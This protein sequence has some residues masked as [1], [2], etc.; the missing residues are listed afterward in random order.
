MEK[1]DGSIKVAACH[2]WLGYYNSI[3]EIGRD[4]TT[5]VE[6]V[7][8]V[9][10]LAKTSFSLQEDSAKNGFEG[11]TWNPNPKIAVIEVVL[12]KLLRMN[13]VD[14]EHIQPLSVWI[15]AQRTYKSGCC[16]FFFFLVR[17]SSHICICTKRSF[18]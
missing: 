11:Y 7:F 15:L 4:K 10:W 13:I 6:P 8:P 16:L 14:K 2:A 9:N 5:L 1:I 17:L 3:R 12:C 18:Y